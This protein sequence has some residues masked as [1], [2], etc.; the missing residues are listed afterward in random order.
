MAL[1]EAE[2]AEAAGATA[3]VTEAGEIL[4]ESTIAEV[5]IASVA[6]VVWIEVVEEAPGVD[7]VEVAQAAVA[8]VTE[9]DEVPVDAA[10]RRNEE[11]A[12]QIP[13]LP[14]GHVLTSRLH[15]PRMAMLLRHPT[16]V[17]PITP[18]EVNN[19]RHSSR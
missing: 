1:R 18:M 5:T 19:N 2:V 8:S 4:A 9:V 15:N 10:A 16:M 11:V 7:Q 17:A 3:S 12:R 6:V 14:R 13:D